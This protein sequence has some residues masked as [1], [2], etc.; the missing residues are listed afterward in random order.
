MLTLTAAQEECFGRQSARWCYLVTFTIGSDTFSFVSGDRSLFGYPAS[1]STVSPVA[2]SIDPLTRKASRGRYVLTFMDDGTFRNMATNYRLDGKVCTISLG[3]QDIAEGDFLQVGVGQVSDWFG[4]DGVR[5]TCEIQNAVSKLSAYT[6][7]AAQPIVSKHPLEVL[8]DLHVGAG[9]D[10]ALY[11]AATMDPTDA[12]YAST[13]SHWSTT[14]AFIAGDANSPIKTTYQIPAGLKGDVAAAQILELLGGALVDGGNGKSKYQ[15][16]DPDAAVAGTW[17]EAEAVFR[18]KTTARH[19]A[20]KII[21]KGCPLENDVFGSSYERQDDDSVSDHGVIDR[22]H[23][24][25]WITGIGTPANSGSATGSGNSGYWLETTDTEDSTFHLLKG[26]FTGVA[27]A[28]FNDSG[29]PGLRS[30]TRDTNA[31]TTD[32]RLTYLMITNGGVNDP[33]IISVKQIEVGDAPLDIAWPVGGEFHPNTI[34]CTIKDRGLFDTTAQD[35]PRQARETWIF[36]VTAMIYRVTQSLKRFKR[37]IAIMAAT[38]SYKEIA[39]EAGDLMAAITSKHIDYGQDGSG[40]SDKWEI[41]RKEIH[42]HGRIEWLLGYVST[43][44]PVSITSTTAGTP[45]IPVFDYY[46]DSTGAIYLNAFGAA[47]FTGG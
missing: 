42:P 15:D 35:W 41:L 10:S 31:E 21:W 43:V 33:E 2:Q 8:E 18:P 30:W 26:G 22:E 36:D 47:Y 40:S 6:V 9:V 11:D 46:Y 7:P 14:R 27:G 32:T 17:T 29:S 28:R 12:A 20:N 23:R 16:Y 34:K 13:H 39:F 5:I 3:A 1:L 38:T 25:P 37:G 45:V 44:D 4:D 19:L 24:S